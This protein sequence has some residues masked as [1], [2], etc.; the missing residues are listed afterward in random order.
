MITVMFV[1]VAVLFS[2]KIT[3]NLAVPYALAARALRGDRSQSKGISLMPFV[4][5]VL[6]LAALVLSLIRCSAWPWSAG[7][8]IFIGMS[9]V[10]GSY[11]HLVVAGGIAGWI[12][13]RLRDHGSGRPG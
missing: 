7:G 9:M 3:W 10:I 1:V 6:L 13:R 8:V 2:I 5:I 12:A 4:E 11:V